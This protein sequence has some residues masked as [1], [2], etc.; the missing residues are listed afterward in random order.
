MS[1]T[2]ANLFDENNKVWDVIVAA[3]EL[4]EICGE[5]KDIILDDEFLKLVENYRKKRKGL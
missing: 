2:E 4:I 3:D 1:E 5:Y